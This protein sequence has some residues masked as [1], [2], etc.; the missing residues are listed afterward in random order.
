MNHEAGMRMRRPAPDGWSVR[1][2]SQCQGAAWRSV[3]NTV[4][5][6]KRMR[7]VML[8]VVRLGAWLPL[9]SS[10]AKITFPGVGTLV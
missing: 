9:T 2:V 7:D 8:T 1:L 3:W 5:Q 4:K 6:N 10:G